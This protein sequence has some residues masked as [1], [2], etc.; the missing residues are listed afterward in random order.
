ME[1]LT[2]LFTELKYSES[3][4]LLHVSGLDIRAMI[5]QHLHEIFA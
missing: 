1:N 2:R 3:K 4:F 5:F